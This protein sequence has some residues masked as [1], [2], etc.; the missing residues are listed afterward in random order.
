MIYSMKNL[1]L[2]LMFIL[3]SVGFSQ[4]DGSKVM[5]VNN[6][7]YRLLDSLIIVEINKVRDSLGN[8]KMNYSKVVS[9][10]VSKRTCDI[11]YKE[12]HVYH[13]D[14]RE[15]LFTEKLESK[16]IKESFN[17][18]GNNGGDDVNDSFEICLFMMKT[19]KQVTY[20]DIALSI[21]DLWESSPD[22]FFV[23]RDAYNKKIT[24]TNHEI[25]IMS[26]ASTKYGIWNGRN[27]F[28]AT[29]NLTVVY[30]N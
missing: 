29:L 21:V 25:F 1:I 5:D 9:D 20:G 16:I 4:R 13:P 10:N 15:N 28:Y 6:I 11:M 24:K 14:G 22:H 2:I 18:Y 30:N 7:D 23:V 26:G 19:Y 8:C 12:Q 17:S 27:G 3:P